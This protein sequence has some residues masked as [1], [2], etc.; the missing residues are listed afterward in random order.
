MP[1]EILKFTILASGNTQQVFSL[2]LLK[3]EKTKHL[4]QNIA[5]YRRDTSR[6]WSQKLSGSHQIAP[7][8]YYL[9]FGSPFHPHEKNVTIFYIHS[10]TPRDWDLSCLNTTQWTGPGPR[11]TG[12]STARAKRELMPTCSTPWWSPSR[13]VSS[14]SFLTVFLKLFAFFFQFYM[15]EGL[16]DNNRSLLS[17]TI[18]LIP[19]WDILFLLNSA[20]RNSP[21]SERLFLFRRLTGCGSEE[22]EWNY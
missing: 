17:G 13:S 6:G 3:C 9:V 5:I 21:T 20:Q 4:C 22:T 7:G 12:W 2:N 8:E 15:V 14:V 11:P 16:H 19:E 18:Y 1:P 10:D